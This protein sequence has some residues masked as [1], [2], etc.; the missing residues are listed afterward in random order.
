MISVATS[1]S[2][3]AADI[4]AD[5]SGGKPQMLWC[6]GGGSSSS[7]WSWGAVSARSAMSARAST[8]FP[9]RGATCSSPHCQTSCSTTSVVSKTDM[10]GSL[11]S[12]KAAAFT[13][14]V[15]KSLP[16]LNRNLESRATDQRWPNPR[17]ASR[18][19]NSVGNSSTKSCVPCAV[20]IPN[21][22]A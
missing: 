10:R 1:A 16:F 20:L 14:V 5:R 12:K 11:K 3:C 4:I 21:I 15:L 19:L 8:G 6:R 2:C 9:R 7:K 22:P 18:P 13:R 17:S